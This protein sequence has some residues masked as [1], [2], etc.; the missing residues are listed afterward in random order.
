MRP[1]IIALLITVAVILAVMFFGTSTGFTV[2]K[3]DKLSVSGQHALLTPQTF[4]PNWDGTADVVHVTVS[5]SCNN[6]KYSALGIFSTDG[7]CATGTLT[8]IASVVSEKPCSTLSGYCNFNGYMHWNGTYSSNARV[9]DGSYC[10]ISGCTSG[11]A[12][13]TSRDKVIQINVNSK[14][15]P[16]K[17]TYVNGV[18]CGSKPT[19]KPSYF[20]AMNGCSKT[21]TQNAGNRCNAKDDTCLKQDTGSCRFNGVTCLY[22]SNYCCKPVTGTGVCQATIVTAVPGGH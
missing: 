18:V 12:E 15:Y 3:F 1:L 22:D 10:V 7:T 4:S 20:G 5:G 13:Q 8:S 11:T 21:A 17:S 9:P 19:C 16:A 2:Y 6:N 14:L